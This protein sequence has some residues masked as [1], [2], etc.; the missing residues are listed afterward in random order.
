MDFPDVFCRDPI[1]LKSVHGEPAQ[2]MLPRSMAFIVLDNKQKT[3]VFSSQ[4]GLNI[5]SASVSKSL[6]SWSGVA[7][8]GRTSKSSKS[9]PSVWSPGSFDKTFCGADA[10]S[11]AK[12]KCVRICNRW[13]F[14]ADLM[15]ERHSSGVPAPEKHVEKD[16]PPGIE[17]KF[18]LRKCMSRICMKRAA[19]ENKCASDARFLVCW[20]GVPVPSPTP[21]VDE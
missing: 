6:M 7:E 9:P 2:C 15:A 21:L 19:H 8:G 16:R 11:I 12:V 10:T 5:R 1:E 14:K 4:A 3:F 20:S 13:I 17:K 18:C